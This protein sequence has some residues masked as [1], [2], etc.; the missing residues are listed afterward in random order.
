MKALFKTL[1]L[2]AGLLAAPVLALAQSAPPPPNTNPADVQPGAYSVEPL[3]TRVLFALSHMGFTTWYG[4]FTHV[5]GA[6]TLN[7][8]ALGAST[9][10]IIIPANTI[11]TSNT[12]VD[13]ELNSPAW[14]DTTKYP[15]IEFK[16]TGIVRTGHDTAKVT[17]DLTF[18]GVTRPETLNVTFNAAGVNFLSKQ[19]TVGFNATGI[20]KRSDFGESTYVPVI[21]DDVS[22]IISAAF[23][24]P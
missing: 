14:L 5:S 18:H 16:S 22:L 19:Y 3:H 10:D 2:G 4:E 21:G 1:A 11:S 23:V 17:G 7:P 20:I 12:K 13:G 9:L 6:L 24:K 15:T 8:K